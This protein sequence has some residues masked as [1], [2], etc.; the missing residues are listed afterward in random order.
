MKNERQSSVERQEVVSD[1][2][3]GEVLA[4]LIERSG[5]TWF[6][7]KDA[8]S[9]GL[10]KKGETVLKDELKK[11]ISVR[12]G[13]DLDFLIREVEV[14]YSDKPIVLVGRD[15]KKDFSKYVEEYDSRHE[16][17]GRKLQDKLAKMRKEQNEKTKKE[18]LEIKYGKQASAKSS[19]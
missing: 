14:D 19:T 1:I 2:G 6:K 5:K 3:D 17:K 15:S 16:K 13:L 18:F 9:L 4:S 12:V 8:K 7:E 11:K 10:V